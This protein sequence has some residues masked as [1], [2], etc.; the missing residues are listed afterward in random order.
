MDGWFVKFEVGRSAFQEALEAEQAAISVGPPVARRQSR[1]EHRVIKLANA[2]LQSPAETKLREG[3]GE[4]RSVHP[5]AALVEHVR[6]RGARA[7]R[8]QFGDSIGNFDH[9][10]VFIILN[11]VENL[12]VNDFVRRSEYGCASARRILHV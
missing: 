11:H 10:V 8:H 5:I 9:P 7:V 1:A 6:R 2:A 3:A 12:V 4:F